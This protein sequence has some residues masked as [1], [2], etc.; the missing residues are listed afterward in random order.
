MLVNTS[1]MLAMAKKYKYGIA[2]ANAWDL[3]S[4]RAII[5]ASQN[6]TCPII[7]GLAEIHFKYISPEELA[8][9]ASLYASKMQTPLALHLDHGMSYE[10]IVKAIRSGFTSVMIDASGLPYEENVKI[11]SEI[12]K[13]GHACNVTVEAELGHVGIGLEYN[14]SNADFFTNPKQAKDFVDRTGIDSLAVAIGTAHGEYNGIPRLDFDRLIEIAKM[15]DVPLV[16][17]GGSGTGDDLLYKAVKSGISKVNICTDL[18][19]KAASEVQKQQKNLNYADLGI[20]GE[21]AII[22]CLEHYFEIFE[23]VGRAGDVQ[24]VRRFQ[25]IEADDEKGFA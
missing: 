12:V 17:H 2:Q 13:L 11:T 1:Q 7:V 14:D 21:E 10:T 22:Q 24:Y 20:I 3:Q 5:R 8:Q 9:L 25:M 23:C 4:L 16:L 6:C 15:V 19:N 18:M